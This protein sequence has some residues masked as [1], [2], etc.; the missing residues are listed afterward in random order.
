M[1]Q[2]GG[3]R[4]GLLGESPGTSRPGQPCLLEMS[5]NAVTG[6]YGLLTTRSEARSLDLAAKTMRQQ[7]QATA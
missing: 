4:H 3:R 5:G 6:A 2:P 1:L 7:D